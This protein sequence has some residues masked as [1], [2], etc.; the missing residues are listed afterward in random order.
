MRGGL[1]KGRLPKI[2]TKNLYTIITWALTTEII[3]VGS[4]IWVISRKTKRLKTSRD[5]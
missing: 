3:G 2:P 5:K 1:T 4:S